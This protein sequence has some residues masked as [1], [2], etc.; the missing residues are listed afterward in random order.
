M[1]FLQVPL[2]ERR[3]IWCQLSVIDDQLAHIASGRLPAIASPASVGPQTNT[4]DRAKSPV[5]VGNHTL[6]LVENGT[7][8]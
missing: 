3:L 2:N 1:T 5:L 7:R 8:R 4:A 6:R